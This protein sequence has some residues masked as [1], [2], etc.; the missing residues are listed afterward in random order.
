MRNDASIKH[1]KGHNMKQSV[2]NTAIATSIALIS[3]NSLAE[4]MYR[5]GWYLVPGVSEVITDQDLNAKNAQGVFIRLGKELTQNIDIQAGLSYS[6]ANVTGIPFAHGHY[7]QTALGLDALYLFSR[8]QFRPFLLAGV[9]IADNDLNYSGPTPAK[10][11]GLDHERKTWMTN[12]GFGAQY[13][14]TDQFGLQADVRQQ[15]SRAKG[16][17]KDTISLKNN[18]SSETISQ[19]VFNIGAIFRF[20][21]PDMVPV[22]EPMP[23]PAPV[24][25]LT[26]KPMPEPVAIVPVPEKVA[27]NPTFKTITISAEKLFGFDDSDLQAG[28]N[29]LLDTV[30]EQLKAH[31]E[32]K[33][34]MINGHTDR[35]GAT[36]YNQKLSERRA[37]H[38]KAYLTSQGIEASRLQAVGKGESEPVVACEG[39]RGK[40]LVECLQ[41]NRR[42]EIQ[43][44]KQHEVEDQ[45]N[46]Q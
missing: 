14:I 30:V 41:P 2:L 40:K 16:G 29:P 31:P 28:P 17:L 19:T 46:C 44:E 43:D 1:T 5:G 42:V 21:A 3:M 33:L 8:D 6:R 24:A 4:D 18:N 7:D 25:A 34:L 37:N 27:C 32:F 13:L 23:E 36:A 22:A 26:P 45:T 15:W 12:V 9:G 35:I 38:V 11:N 20:G 10:L 39:I